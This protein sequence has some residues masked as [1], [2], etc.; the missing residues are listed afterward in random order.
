M[1]EPRTFHF[2]SLIKLALRES[3]RN[4][5]FDEDRITF[6]LC[7]CERVIGLWKA[8]WANHGDSQDE[9][10][11][12][13]AC[14]MRGIGKDL[15]SARRA[16][17]FPSDNTWEIF[18]NMWRIQGSRRQ[19]ASEIIFTLG[20]LE[21]HAYDCA[22]KLGAW[23][24]RK[25]CEHDFVSEIANQYRRVFHERPSGSRNGN[26]FAVVTAM[27]SYVGMPAGGDMVIG[28]SLVASEIESKQSFWD[29]DDN[30]IAQSKR[31]GASY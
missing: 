17:E 14:E 20:E 25:A 30:L 23:S 15:R 9:T 7:E 18:W 6:F 19:E 31:D 28:G 22:A 2:D 24:Q 27:A 3:L 13:S 5:Y 29:Y 10:R 16:L 1:E 4:K 11:K 8:S 26:F 21:R 12:Q